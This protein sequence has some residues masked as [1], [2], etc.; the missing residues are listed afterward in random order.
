[1]AHLVAVR[2]TALLRTVHWTVPWP[3]TRRQNSLSHGIRSEFESRS[4]ERRLRKAEAY[5]IYVEHFRN[6]RSFEIGQILNGY[7]KRGCGPGN[8][9]LPRDGYLYFFA[10]FFR[11]L[12]PSGQLLLP[13]DQPLLDRNRL[14]D[15][16]RFV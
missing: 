6:L 11:R 1:M 8:H 2:R 3:A 12:L 15:L 14:R 9:N 10:S 5:S 16:S 7:K 4:K 13:L